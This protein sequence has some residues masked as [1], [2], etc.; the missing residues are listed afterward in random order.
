[1]PDPTQPEALTRLDHWLWCVRL[2]P[3]RSRAVEAIRNGDVLVN[4]LPAKPSRLLRHGDL[5]RIETRDR[6]RTFRCLAAPRSRV[7][8]AAVPSYAEDCTP[9]GDAAPKPTASTRAPERPRGLGRPTKRERRV[10]E[11]FLHPPDDP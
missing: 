6:R 8:A 4:G 10:L 9:P 11:Q 5:V 1:M 2:A 3:S 7:G